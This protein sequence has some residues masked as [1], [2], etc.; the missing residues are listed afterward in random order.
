MPFYNE[1]TQT[2]EFNNGSVDIICSS[3]SQLIST[4]KEL[5]GVNLLTFLN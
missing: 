2:F 4:A 1:F 5:G 3:M